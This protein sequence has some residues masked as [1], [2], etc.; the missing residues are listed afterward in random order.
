MIDVVQ[1]AVVIRNVTR[2]VYWNSRFY[3]LRNSITEEDL[4]Q[5]VYLKLLSRDNCARYSEEYSLVSFLYRVA[6]GC[7]INYSKKNMVQKESTVLDDD[8]PNPF[9]SVPSSKSLTDDPTLRDLMKSLEVK[10]RVDTIRKYMS[11]VNHSSLILRY[12][13]Q[14]IPFTMLN[15]FNLFFENRLSRKEMKQCIISKKTNAPVLK[16]TFKKLWDS[17]LLSAQ[18]TLT[19]YV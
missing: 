9:I 6:N 2:K 11:N 13:G 16:I 12:N 8:E 4:I 14:D 15:M 17:M 7:A 19:Y 18:N 1:D 10:E 5:M 3:A